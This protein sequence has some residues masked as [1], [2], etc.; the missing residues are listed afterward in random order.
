MRSLTHFPHGHEFYPGTFDGAIFSE[1][2]FVT[3]RSIL[4]GARRSIAIPFIQMS[5]VIIC[6]RIAR[7]SHCFGLI[8]SWM[9]STSIWGLH[10]AAHNVFCRFARHFSA[11]QD[12]FLPRSIPLN[13]E[14]LSDEQIAPPPS[15]N[16]SPSEKSKL[17]DADS[18]VPV[19]KTQ[20]AAARL[21]DTHSQ[22]G[23]GHKITKQNI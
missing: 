6:S 2:T 5:V 22:P 9:I 13:G 10:S 4:G 20:V 7:R 17:C 3:F 11:Q 21:R 1:L 23:V 14:R 16:G 18:S 15:G 19:S 8:A 12:S